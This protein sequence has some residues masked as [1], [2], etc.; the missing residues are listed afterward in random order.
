VGWG[1]GGEILIIE[2]YVDISISNYFYSLKQNAEEE[3]FDYMNCMT[4]VS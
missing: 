4:L 3:W 2:T 1:R